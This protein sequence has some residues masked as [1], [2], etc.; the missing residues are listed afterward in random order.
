M[1]SPNNIFPW[2]SLSVIPVALLGLHGIF[3]NVSMMEEIAFEN[4][5]HDVRTI[6][7]NTANF[8]AS[9]EGDLRLLKNVPSLQRYVHAVSH[10]V[11]S[12]HDSRQLS[13]ELI[14]WL[15]TK[16]IYY[17]IRLVGVTCG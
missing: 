8:L 3:S 1:V 11:V 6:R 17:Q 13:E 12:E 9:V 10:S 16:R 7:E 14:A 15:Q 2:L 4:L 5:T